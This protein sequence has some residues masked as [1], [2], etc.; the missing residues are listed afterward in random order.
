MS[1]TPLVV[2][3]WKMN[4]PSARDAV[5]LAAAVVDAVRSRAASTAST[6]ICPP[7]IWLSEIAREVERQ[8]VRLGAQNMCAQ[9]SG[10]FTGETSAAML[11]A[12]AEFV[13]IGHSERRRLYGETDEDVR[14]K[15]AAAVRHGLRPIA[16]LGERIEERQAGRT[17]E[18]IERQTRSAIARLGRIAGSGLIVAY[19]PVWA[20]GTGRAAD[21]EDAQ[22]A[23]AQIRSILAEADPAGAAEVPILYGGSVTADNAPLFFAQ[24]DVDGALVGGAS[25]DPVAFARIVAAADMRSAGR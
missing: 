9:D 18:V 12:L 25:L 8:G 2:G 23:A 13:I 6:V 1:R 17:A 3:N 7:T 14:D 20:I 11:L 4:P 5:A 16:A 24:S 19:E 15:V 21:E 22:R 10:A